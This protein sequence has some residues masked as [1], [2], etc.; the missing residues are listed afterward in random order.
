MRL[1]AVELD[2]APALMRVYSGA[3]ARFT[4]GRAITL[5]EARA[6]IQAALDRAAENPRVQ[7]NWGIVV[8]DELI[9]LITL[10][11]RSPTMGSISYSLREDRWGH[12]Y[13]TE[14]VKHVVSFAFTTIGVNR[15]EAMHHPDNPASGRVLTKSGFLCTGTHDQHEGGTVVPYVVY[16]VAA[17]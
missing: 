8:D 1:R 7:W 13:A 9:G 17:P 5:A 14:A 10:R 16:A 4:T 11:R 12:G 6:K 15:V 2:D 3:T